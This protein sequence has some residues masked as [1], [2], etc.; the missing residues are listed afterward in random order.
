MMQEGRQTETQLRTFLE[1]PFRASS[2]Q[3][4]NKGIFSV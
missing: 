4:F 2:N 3:V 1:W